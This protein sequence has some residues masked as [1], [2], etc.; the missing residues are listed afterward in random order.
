MEIKISSN[1]NFPI[2][3]YSNLKANSGSITSKN[4]IQTFKKNVIFDNNNSLNSTA[5]TSKILKKNN[6]VN[7]QKEFKN[8]NG[9]DE[10]K[11]KDTIFQLS[12]WDSEHLENSQ[13]KDVKI[14]NYFNQEIKRQNELIRKKEEVDNL[15]NQKLSLK[16]LLPK[17]KSE[18]ILI[19]NKS[20]IFTSKDKLINFKVLIK[21]DNENKLFNEYQD[22]L[23]G[24][25]K[26]YFKEQKKTELKHREALMDIYEK[27]LINKLK[28]RKYES[29]LNDTCKLLESARIEYNLCI[30]IIKERIKSVE[31]YYNAFIHKK[32]NINNCNINSN[33]NNQSNNSNIN[34]N[35]SNI[36]FHSNIDSNINNLE[37]KIKMEHNLKSD[38]NNVSYLDDNISNKT[39]NSGESKK[40]IKR[41]T[42]SEII[43]EKV[44]KYNEFNSIKNDL[45]LELKGY[46]DRFSLIN[47]QLSKIIKKAKEKL[48]KCDDN[49][50]YYKS[51]F[52]EFSN[53][54]KKYYLDILKKGTDTRNQGL[55]WVVKRLIELKVNIDT[56]MFPPFLDNEQIEYIINISKLGFEKSQLKLILNVLKHRNRKT[57]SQNFIHIYNFSEKKNGVNIRNFIKEKFKREFFSNKFIEQ[58]GNLYL[59]HEDFTKI[60][61]EK[62]VEDN[63]IKNIV[64][65]NKTKLHQYAINKNIFDEKKEE[66]FFKIF[67]EHQKQKRYFDD[68][69]QINNRI[70]EL[71]NFINLLTKE[72]TLIFENKIKFTKLRKEESMNDFKDKVSKALFGTYTVM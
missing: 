11:I 45:L 25:S 68:I 4:A 53:D 71:N 61:F 47:E 62:K 29:I 42:N 44:R 43:E 22:N 16:E 14:I 34:N 33:N 58:M 23:E 13:F 30:D 24:I 5:F 41:K 65:E 18:R 56:N 69:I 26:E 12:I 36:D 19:K 21:D 28:K 31:K 66:N 32:N 38:E 72:E 50:E 10:K 17:I 60:I 9:N 51:L 59:K 40:K 3:N 27:I 54:Q 46:D 37:N 8:K 6:S 52:V 48:K 64:H 49:K 55:T 15:I 1:L 2:R 35:S 70:K 7:S 20:Q 63:I 39:Q 57:N 67:M